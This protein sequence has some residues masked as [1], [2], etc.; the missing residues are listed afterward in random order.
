MS[1][2]YPEEGLGLGGPDEENH[3][4]TFIASNERKANSYKEI[5]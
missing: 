5:Q 1:N 2:D 4:Y 3:A